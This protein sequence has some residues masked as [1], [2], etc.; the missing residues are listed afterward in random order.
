MMIFKGLINYYVTN[1]RLLKIKYKKQ[2]S[3][4]IKVK[5]KKDFEQF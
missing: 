3:P 5:L 2:D 1:I 4:S